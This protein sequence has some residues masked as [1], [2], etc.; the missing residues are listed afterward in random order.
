M[1]IETYKINILQHLNNFK[2][3]HPCGGGGARMLPRESEISDFL[4]GKGIKSNDTIKA[5]HSSPPRVSLAGPR[6]AEGRSLG[7]AAGTGRHVIVQL[8]ER[9]FTTEISLQ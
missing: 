7:A 2:T 3:S 6:Q 5:K 9:L 8:P 1:E 4:R